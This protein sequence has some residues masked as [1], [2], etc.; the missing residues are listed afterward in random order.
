MNHKN[1]ISILFKSYFLLCYPLLLQ[2]NPIPSGSGMSVVAPATISQPGN[3]RLANDIVGTVTIDADN[4]D[5]CLENHV[6]SGG[7]NNIEVLPEHENV[8]IHNGVIQEATNRGIFIN[9]CTNITIANID[10]I[11]N[12]TVIDAQTTVCIF[13]ENCSFRNNTDQ[14]ILYSN[15]TNSKINNCNF[16]FNNSS[17]IIDISNSVDTNLSALNINS[18]TTTAGFIGV[19]FLN[20]SNCN[21]FMSNINHNSSID[22]LDGIQINTCNSCQINSTNINN[23]LVNNPSIGVGPF[24]GINILSSNQCLAKENAIINN[25]STMGTVSCI[26]L[27]SSNEC[28]ID[29]NF[30]SSNN[31]GFGGA[32][33][34]QTGSSTNNIYFRNIVQDTGATNFSSSVGPIA[35]YDPTTFTLTTSQDVCIDNISVTSP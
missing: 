1:I 23:N 27:D 7:F 29:N 10:F 25:N 3:Y 5:F 26:N 31:G 24:R 11:Q 2:A 32:G 34:N 22:S 14:S 33:I 4:V 20:S 6:I 19:R 28:F 35:L 12:F 16:E 21:I 8:F 18:N 17:F 15:I 9:T 30:I 13:I